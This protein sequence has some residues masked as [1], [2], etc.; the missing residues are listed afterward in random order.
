LPI[1]GEYFDLWW[2]T[3]LGNPEVLADWLRGVNTES[4]TAW[5]RTLGGALLQRLVLFAFT[6]VTLFLMLRD[7]AWL[8]ERARR[9]LPATCSGIPASAWSERS[10]TPSAPP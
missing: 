9:P 10:L 8:A 1:A 4:I 2:R 7:G 3:N 6:L 5:T